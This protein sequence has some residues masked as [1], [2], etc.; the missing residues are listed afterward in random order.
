VQT[1]ASCTL[2]DLHC[3]HLRK[4]LESPFQLG[5]LPENSHQCFAIKTENGKVYLRDCPSSGP[6]ENPQSVVSRQIPLAR[7]NR[8]PHSFH[9]EKRSGWKSSR[10]R[11][12]TRT[13]KCLPAHATHGE[14]ST[15][16]IPISGT[17][18]PI[19]WAAVRA[20]SFVDMPSLTIAGG[21]F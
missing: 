8:L 10:S 18:F 20:V 16:Q 13:S 4:L 3:H 12:N 11:R 17:T 6:C 19:L 2:G 5:T 21:R 15:E 9:R 1:I 14:L 7:P